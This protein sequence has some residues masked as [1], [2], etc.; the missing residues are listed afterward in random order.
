VCLFG[1]MFRWPKEARAGKLI[2]LTQN[3]A[4]EISSR[5]NR[6][7]IKHKDAKAQRN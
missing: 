3:T 5:L 1:P 6:K 7:E 4:R 2:E